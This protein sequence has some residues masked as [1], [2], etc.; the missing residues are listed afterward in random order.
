MQYIYQLHTH[1]CER[2]SACGVFNACMTFWGKTALQVLPLLGAPSLSAINVHRTPWCNRDNMHRHMT[3]PRPA[4]GD[5]T[6]SPIIIERLITTVAHSQ[7]V[8]ADKSTSVTLLYQSYSVTRLQSCDSGQ[9]LVLVLRSARDRHER[10]EHGLMRLLRY[11]TTCATMSKQVFWVQAP[12]CV[13]LRCGSFARH[14]RECMCRAH[15][16]RYGLAQLAEG[17]C[18][19]P[20]GF[21]VTLS[22]SIRDF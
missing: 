5:G 22:W 3:G 21:P 13:R 2:T 10:G 8:S 17:L 12:F 6:P 16:R 4:T 11:T 14:M 9:G 19:P 18:S 15:S 7:H 20:S 1:E